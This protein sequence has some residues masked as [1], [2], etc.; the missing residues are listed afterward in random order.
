M[1]RRKVFAHYMVGLT[2]GQTS[3]IW[4]REINTAKLAG[5]DGFALNIGPND[6]WTKEQLTKAYKAAEQA[7]RFSLFLSFDM[8]AGSWSVPQVVDLIRTYSGS[9]AQ[10]RVD[11]LPLVSTFEGPGWAGNWAA[12]RRE[13]G[14][15]CLIP[16]WSSLGPYGVGQKLDLIDGAF[17]WDAWPKAE[18]HRMTTVEDHLYKENLRGKKYMMGVSPWFYTDL[19][20]W[21]KH[22]YSSSESLWFDRWQ[23]VLEIRPDFVQIIT[24]NDFGESSYISD[25]MPSQVVSGAHGY[26]SDHS[27]AGFRAV[28]P[29][30]IAAYKA[31]TGESSWTGPDTVCAWYR[32]MPVR[33]RGVD[34]RSGRVSAV[35]GARDVISV[36]AVTKGPAS[37]EVSIGDSRRMT[38]KTT[39]TSPLSYFELP[40]S[41]STTGPVGLALNGKRVVGP[42]ITNGPANGKV[43][44]N[45]VS[46]HVQA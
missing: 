39:G 12:V 15:I 16:S 19:H 4:I 42:E 34:R 8:A 9:P 2:N 44:L 6:P 40:F 45:A 10:T 22:W 41:R 25:I 14:G 46:I 38:L 29:Y 3:D 17:S 33:G 27:H 18:Q 37:I 13:T 36:M 30:L 32:T 43:S 23:Q 21:N 1:D 31:G 26:I 5:I 24:W 11:G 7:T 28:L 35:H 20:Q